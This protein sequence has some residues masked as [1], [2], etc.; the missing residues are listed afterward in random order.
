MAIARPYSTPGAPAECICLNFRQHPARQ[1]KLDFSELDRKVARARVVLSLL[2]LI[3]LYVDPSTG[4]LFDVT[5]WQFITLIC[6][7]FYSSSMYLVLRRGV[8]ID[9]V[10]KFSIA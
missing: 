10:R 6:H 8:H 1:M 3:S 7:L 2:V 4:G 9:S 5:K